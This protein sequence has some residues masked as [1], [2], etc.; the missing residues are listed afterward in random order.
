[1]TKD[2]LGDRMKGYEL[3]CRQTLPKR[4]PVIIRVDGKAFHTLT[5]KLQKPF[6]DEFMNLMDATAK[7]LCKEVQGTQLAYVQ[8]D[9]I[10]LLVHGYK[11]LDSQSWFDNQIQKMVSVAAS[12]AAAYFNRFSPASNGIHALASFDARV[13]VL[14][15]AEVC[16]YFIWRQQDAI[17]NSVQM[18]ARAHFSASLCHRKKNSEL[19]DMLVR[20]A[21]PWGELSPEKQQGRVFERVIVTDIFGERS[22]WTALPRPARF[23]DDRTTVERHL[24]LDPEEPKSAKA[25]GSNPNEAI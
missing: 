14:P 25:S 2:S 3:A 1:M 7:H 4:L 18:M 19:K 20:N 9:E 12:S 8:S 11:K 17:R 16:N 10:S 23:Q 13:F 21:T 24:A 6:D 22:H 15:E 5:R